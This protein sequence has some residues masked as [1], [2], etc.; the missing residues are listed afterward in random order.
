MC[1]QLEKLEQLKKEV[2]VAVIFQMKKETKRI[3]DGASFIE[4]ILVY[5]CYK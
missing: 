2:Y 1:K 5:Q 3:Q 4:Y